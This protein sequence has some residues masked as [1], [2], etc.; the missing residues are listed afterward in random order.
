MKLIE[1]IKQSRRDFQGKYECQSCGNIE[2][3]NGYDSYDDDFYH[4][5]VIPA[6]KCKKCGE[7]TN[8][9]KLP[10]NRVATKYEASEVI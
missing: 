5:N 4:D 2:T 10:N 6:M 7:S 3:D 8:S 9:L 1:K